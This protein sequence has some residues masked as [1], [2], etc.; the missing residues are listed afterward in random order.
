M[1]RNGGVHNHVAIFK[2]KRLILCKN[3]VRSS[4]QSQQLPKKHSKLTL[5]LW[6]RRDENF[7]N[8]GKFGK[9]A[10][11]RFICSKPCP[12]RI[13]NPEFLPRIARGDAVW[14]R[15]L[16]RELYCINCE[17]IARN[18]CNTILQQLVMGFCWGVKHWS[19]YVLCCASGT[20]IFDSMPQE[21]YEPALKF[22]VLVAIT[23]HRLQFHI[24]KWKN[25][26]LF[27]SRNMAMRRVYRRGAWTRLSHSFTTIYNTTGMIGWL[28]KRLRKCERRETLQRWE[29][30]STLN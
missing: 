2:I 22:V 26:I 9:S 16:W 11:K 23:I 29:D 8:P 24:L 14:G 27:Y 10:R 13:D 30:R 19:L 6:G 4:L 18:I 12:F 1:S 20:R 17:D 25:E 28:Q 15:F 5:G 7:E 3:I 21:E